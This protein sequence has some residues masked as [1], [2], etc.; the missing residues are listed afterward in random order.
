MFFGFLYVGFFVAREDLR[1]RRNFGAFFKSLQAP[2]LPRWADGSK[3]STSRVFAAICIFWGLGTSKFFMGHPAG[4]FAECIK[5][6][7]RGVRQVG[8]YPGFVAH[9]LERTA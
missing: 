2:A 8:Y 9:P 3:A 1:E 5:S 6:K 7:R 4:S